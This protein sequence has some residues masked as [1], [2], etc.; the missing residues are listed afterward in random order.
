MGEAHG[1][2]AISLGEISSGG[3]KIH[4]KIGR[5][6]HGPATISSGGETREKIQLGREAQ[7]I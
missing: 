4:I 3:A 6:A 5:T 2:T 1:H 7:K